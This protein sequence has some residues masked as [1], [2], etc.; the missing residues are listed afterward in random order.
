MLVGVGGGA[1]IVYLI[2]DKISFSRG[3]VKIGKAACVGHRLSELQIGNPEPLFVLFSV[4]GDSRLEERLHRHFENLRVRAEWFKLGRNAVARVQRALL[5]KEVS[6]PVDR[7]IESIR[8][9][10]KPTSFSSVRKVI[11]PLG[12]LTER[13]VEVATYISSGYSTAQTAMNLEL[14]LRTVKF[15]STNI[16]RKLGVRG[17][18][19]LTIRMKFAA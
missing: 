1:V 10:L 17:R 19:D 8:P 11:D 13:E 7:Q 2:S 5:V 15:H 18:K 6:T 14:A 4:E 12:L 9:F 3:L 16:Y